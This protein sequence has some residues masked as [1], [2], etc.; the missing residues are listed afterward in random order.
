MSSTYKWLV[1]LVAC[2]VA[3]GTIGFFAGVRA[4]VWEHYLRDSSAKASV[5]THE[6][7]IL[8]AGKTD[9]L[10]EAKEAELDGEIYTF[11]R[12]LEE[13]RPWVFWPESSAYDHDKYMRNVAAYR[14]Q[15]PAVA[16]TRDPG[17]DNPN[18]EQMRS[19]ARD[20]ARRT[21]EILQKYGK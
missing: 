14:K 10:I 5:L 3:A 4:A 9:M 8:R 16:P 15:Y 12:Y 6:L 18:A 13:G 2:A 21:Q 1:A 19:Y 20:V 7:R 17:K 11:G